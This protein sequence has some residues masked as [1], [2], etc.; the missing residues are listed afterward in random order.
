VLS[1]IDL[2]WTALVSDGNEIYVDVCG[3]HRCGNSVA[4]V[5]AKTRVDAVSSLA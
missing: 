1:G 5:A 4:A 3:Q 2:Q